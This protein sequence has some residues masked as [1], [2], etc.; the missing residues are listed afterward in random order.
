MTRRGIMLAVLVAALASLGAASSALAKE[1]QKG[2]KVFNQCPRFTKGVNYCLYDLTKSG[3]VVL[4]KQKVPILNTI[5]LQGGIERNETT[6]AE[7]FVAASNGETLSKTPQNVPGGLTGLINCK[8]ITGEGIVEKIE[9]GSCEAVFEHG[10]TAVNAITELAKPASEIQINK[11]NL[12]NQ[13]GIDLSLPVKIRL[14]NSLLGSECYIGSSSNPVVWSLTTGPTSPPPPNTSIEGKTGK[15]SFSE[16]FQIVTITGNSSV[17]NSFSAPGATGCGG[18]LV[19]YLLDP[20]I[21]AKIGL[22]SAAGKNTAILTG[23]LEEST[24]ESVIKSEA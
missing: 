4:N 9:R 3:E 19:E 2:F 21:N 23:N 15:L 13:E 12:V 22:A 14:E 24:T 18:F 1:P 10:I 20:I 6:E 8:E 11:N 5:T 7:K 16:E 17:N